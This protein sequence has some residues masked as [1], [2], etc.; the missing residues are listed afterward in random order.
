MTSKRGPRLVGLAIVLWGMALAISVG[1]AAVVGY[2]PD[3]VLVKFRAT[4]SAAAVRKAHARARALAANTIPEI[5]VQVIQL[6]STM[7]VPQAL[8]AYGSDPN[9][10]FAEPD[11]IGEPELVPNDP[12]YPNQWFLPKIH[13]PAAWDTTV[14]VSGIVVAILDTG[15]DPTH[16]DLAANLVPGWNAYDGNTDTHDVYGHGTSVAGVVAALGNNGVGVASV[17]WGCRIMPIRISDTTGYGYYS[18]AATGLSWAAD[19]GARVA[20]ISYEFSDSSTVLAAAAY[21]QS[22]GG[23]VTVSAGNDNTVLTIPDS[24]YVLT[25]GATDSNDARASFS[26]T[27]PVV[28]LVAP[29]VNITT[30]A[31]GGGYRT[32]SGTSFSAPIVAGVAALV[33]SVNANLTPAQVQTIVT[34]SADDL[35][36]HG[37]DTTF[38]WGRVNAANAV[39]QAVATLPDTQPPVVSFVSPGNGAVLKGTVQIQV[40]ATDNRGVA[41]VTIGVDSTTPATVASPY[42]L[43]WDTT[44]VAN[45]THTL[46]ATA[47]DTSGNSS[48]ARVTVMVSN[49]VPDTIPPTVSILTPTNGSNVLQTMW[50]S[51]KVSDNVGVVLTEMYMNGTLVGSSTLANPTFYISTTSWPRGACSLQAKAYDAA[52]NVGVSA[53]ITVYTANNPA[54]DSTP[55]SVYISAP[56]DGATLYLNTYMSARASDNVGISEVDLYMDGTL[57]GTSTSATPSWYISTTTWSKGPHTLTA[58]AFDIQKNSAWSAPITVYK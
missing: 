11:G 19:H 32:S 2:V 40:T 8:A 53:K 49:P 54:P 38:G 52:G 14:G 36:A 58:Q 55:P 22:K 26:N 47:K 16:P 46:S 23:V 57:I 28:D 20:N 43:S 24:P 29:G 17:A 12:S 31:N 41:S 15:V 30:T 45:G 27:G 18:T 48:T 39:A 25:V 44:K 6:P 10:E 35:G 7:T 34:S 1:Q 5:G 51:A 50:S 13:G 4:A 37:Y 21:F 56:A 33:L 3:R 9:V 42:T